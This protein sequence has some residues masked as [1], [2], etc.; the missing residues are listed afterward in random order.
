MRT[1]ASAILLVAGL[2]ALPAAAPAEDL[3]PE[4]ILDR[5][6]KTVN[7]FDDQ[8][9]DVTMTVVDVDGSRKSYDFTVWQ[10]GD[11]KRLVRFRSGE[12]KGMATLVED[13]QHVYVYLPGLKKVRRVAAH[14]MNQSF[15][16][17]DMSNDDMA[18]VSW[19]GLYEAAIE[20][21]DADHW[22]LRCTP[23][24]GADA[25]YARATLKVEKKRFL[26]MGIEYYDESGAKVK[27]WDNRDVTDYH[28]VPRA[29]IVELSDPRTGHRTILKVNDLR[30]NQGLTDSM[31]TVRELEWGS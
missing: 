14:N 5:M 3:A 24:P 21:E 23:R 22:Y 11:T 7:G 18:A 4:A 16:G 26:Q 31:F 2:V 27:V 25:P 6:E 19:A 13:R 8:V 10:K 20:R 9:M 28:G 30:V 17:S 12:I 1:T 29:S 15:A